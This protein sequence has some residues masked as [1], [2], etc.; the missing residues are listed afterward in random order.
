M[1]KREL[2]IASVSLAGLGG[3]LLCWPRASSIN[4]V[5]QKRI[6]KGMTR[7]EVEG[8]L[9]GPAGFYAGA[10]MSYPGENDLPRPYGWPEDSITEDWVGNEGKIS[11]I[12]DP[13]ERVYWSQWCPGRHIDLGFWLWLR[14]RFERLVGATK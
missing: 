2:I 7:S 5:N 3:L 14:W 13:N 6:Y 4:E 10:P 1:H 11:V 12:F 9:R 8:I